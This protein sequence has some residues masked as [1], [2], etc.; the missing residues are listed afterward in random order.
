MKSCLQEN[1]ALPGVGQV[2]SSQRPAVMGLAG[3]EPWMAF[4]EPWPAAYPRDH[5]LCWQKRMPTC[6][7][8]QHGG[9]VG[10]LG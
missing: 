6:T 8:G 1:R 9:G 10:R 7:C 2:T 3:E 4:A 5:E